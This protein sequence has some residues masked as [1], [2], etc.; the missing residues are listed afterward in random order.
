MSGIKDI[1]IRL[2]LDASAAIGMLRRQGVGK[3]RHLSTRILWVQQKTASQ[4]VEVCKVRTDVNVADL[5]TKSLSRDV[6]LRLMFLISIVNMDTGEPVGQQ[7]YDNYI[8]VQA[9]KAAVRSLRADGIQRVPKASLQRAIT[10]SVFAVTSALGQY[11]H[12]QDITELN[13]HIEDITEISNHIE[14]I[15][16]ISDHIEDITEINN[17]IEDITEI[18]DHIE[19][20]TEI[21]YHIKGITEISDHVEDITDISD[22]IEDII[23]ISDH[24]EDITDISYHVEGI[25]RIIDI[26]I[27]IIVYVFYMVVVAMLDNKYIGMFVF[28]CGLPRV[29]AQSRID[30]NEVFSWVDIYIFAV[31]VMVFF[32]GRWSVTITSSS[33]TRTSRST[34]TS[35]STSSA[36]SSTTTFNG[37]PE[38]YDDLFEALCVTPQQVRRHRRYRDNGLEYDADLIDRY[39]SGGRHAL[40]E[41]E[42][43]DDDMMTENVPV[44]F[45]SNLYFTPARGEATTCEVAE[46]SATAELSCTRRRCTRDLAWRRVEF[47]TLLCYLKSSPS[48]L[49][50][51][52]AEVSEFLQQ[53][54]LRV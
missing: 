3:V 42:L 19:D 1:K 20:I 8:A 26:A 2:C 30:M 12:A 29:H 44:G 50:R 48:G 36:T 22:H 6:M 52:G 10:M 45:P 5:G 53:V 49:C 18:S 24:I 32:L 15:T 13:N 46:T 27:Y 14:D 47:A 34:I 9:M 33:S 25:K 54:H 35:S 41:K 23:E 11:T 43:D 16:E 40:T 51:S 4:E 31:L 7:A 28:L 37:E 17:H 21:N 39:E 38:Y